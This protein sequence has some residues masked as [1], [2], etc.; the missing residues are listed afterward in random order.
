MD[1]IFTSFADIG[2]MLDPDWLAGLEMVHDLPLTLDDVYVALMSSDLRTSCTCNNKLFQ[3]NSSVDISIPEGQRPRNKSSTKRMLKLELCS[4]K[5]TVHAI[6]IETC[7]DLSDEP[8][9]GTKILVTGS[10]L[11]SNGLVFLTPA[12]I[13]VIGGQVNELMILQKQRNDQRI[14]ARDPL[15]CP[16][17]D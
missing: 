17:G 1:D 6:E 4:G 9:A 2:I 10:P 12:N 7:T 16:I 13:K 3:I 5:K 14:K 11:V 15:K 8:D